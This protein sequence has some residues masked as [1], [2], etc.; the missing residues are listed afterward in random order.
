[1]DRLSRL[2]ILTLL[3]LL[4]VVFIPLLSTGQTIS[5]HNE[6]TF[7]PIAYV[8]VYNKSKSF[9]ALSDE[10][11][12]VHLINVIP[13]DTLY[14]QHPGYYKEQYTLRDIND[15][16]QVVYL[17]DRIIFIGGQVISA[18]KIIER[19][20][21]IPNKINVI[22]AKE[23]S[24]DDAQTTADVL[25]NT[26]N[27]FIQRS[28]MGGG[29]PVIRGFEANK[30]LIVV[31]GVRMNNAIYRS[32]HLQ[33]V[34]TIDKAILE[35][36]EVIFG[37]GSVVFGSDALGGVVN[38]YTWDPK[39]SNSDSL[40]FKTNFY[41]RYSTANHE[42][43]GHVDINLGW[44]NVGSLTS[45]TYSKYDDLRSGSNRHSDYPDFGKRLLF[46]DTNGKDSVMINDDHN[47]QKFTGYEQLDLTQK[48]RFRPDEKVDLVLNLQYSTSSDI[49]RYDRLNDTDNM[50]PI[51]AEWH[52]G[53]QKR[54]QGSMHADIRSDSKLFAT[55]NII[56]AY[57]RIDEDRISRRLSATERSHRKEDV[58]VYSF[59]FDLAKPIGI[60]KFQY[61]LEVV[62]QKVESSAFKENI[63]TLNRSS[64]STRYPGGG[65]HMETV[66]AYVFNKWHLHEKMNLTDGLRFS[67]T[68]LSSAFEDTFFPFSEIAF[69]TSALS[70]SLGLNLMPG[71]DLDMRV[72]ASSGFRVPNVDDVGKVFDSSPGNVI[73]PNEDLKPE[74]AY[75]LEVSIDKTFFEKISLS[76]AAYYTFIN[77][78]IVRRNFMFN[79]QDSIPY[80]GVLSRVQSNVNAGRA[81]IQG[82]SV[83]ILANITTHISFKS[84]LNYTY[85]RDLSEDVPLG[86]IPPLFGQSRLTWHIKRFRFVLYSN[87]NGWKRIADFSPF[88][89]DKS[90]EATPDGSPSWYTLNIRLAI[91]LRQQLRFQ[92]GLENISDL[93]YRPFSSGLS[94]PGR[95]LTIALHG[96]F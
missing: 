54:F 41:T 60:H 48:F 79:G 32:G 44:K 18:R 26:G 27:L 9:S 56:L 47:I 43:S 93:H 66:A 62:T 5:I 1:M 6:T 85:G 64:E 78:A 70:G 59:N 38:F 22:T 45:V 37:P 7:E 68:S 69:T 53:P 42:R 11:G 76:G 19:A 25:T 75:N 72:I 84:S 8:V 20:S 2:R 89:E 87:Y 4:L 50:T 63:T 95:N 65:S 77:D 29:S 17:I 92:V 23:I 49:P 13:S 86:H 30:I 21:E 10:E 15:M 61:G 83:G 16:D 51:Y 96:N 57:Q 90:E 74:N 3:S 88:T 81:T 80:E 73:V 28:Q 31:D 67:L 14:F 24:F 82:F 40:N 52:Y 46:V 35:R 55:G 91:Q 33:N 94:A 34:I 58:D 71:K 12:R 39:L 36:S